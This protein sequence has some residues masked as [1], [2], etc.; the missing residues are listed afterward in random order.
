MTTTPE[1]APNTPEVLEEFSLVTAVTRLDFLAR[2]NNHVVPIGHDATDDEDDWGAIK[3]ATTS[4]DVDEALE[5]LA[6]GEVV[7]RKAH[8]GR[9]EGVLAALRGGAGWADIAAAL[10]VPASYAWDEYSDWLD[11]QGAAR[12]RGDKALGADDVVLARE[13]AGDR[14][15]D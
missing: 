1:V 4:L 10:G 14:P 6:L 2:R 13:L 12:E 3:E 7:A 9:P 8:A 11:G 15:R 5:L